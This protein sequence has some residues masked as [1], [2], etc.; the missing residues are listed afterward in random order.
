[1]RAWRWLLAALALAVALLGGG[2]GWRT[3]RRPRL[4]GA[5]VHFRSLC[6]SRRRIRRRL[7][8]YHNFFR[9]RVRPSASNM[10]A[11]KWSRP[12]AAAAQ[13]W[14]SACR[15]LTHDTAAGRALPRYGACGQNIFVSTHRVPW[16]FAAKTWWL[17]RDNFTFGSS[18]NDLFVVGHY[19]QMVWHSSHQLGC[20]IAY[21]PNAKPL[22]FYNY[23][24]NYCPIGN[25]LH[26]LGRPYSAGAPCQGCP[27]HCRARR[28]CTNACPYGD[29]WINCGDLARALRGWLCDTRTRQ[30][31]ARRRNCQATCR[32]QGKIKFP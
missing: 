18:G 19:T 21:C 6:P 24:C 9:T 23:V 20:G 2:A 16:F 32:C 26:S 28:L 4:F 13:R 10:L 12:V 27:G 29:L 5:R 31:L 3:D 17:E 22:P 8:H 7:V 11:M 25:F 1:M 15:L 30:G 14:A